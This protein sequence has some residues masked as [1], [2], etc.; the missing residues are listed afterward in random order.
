VI[1]LIDHLPAVGLSWSILCAHPGLF[2][3]IECFSKRGGCREIRIGLRFEWVPLGLKFPWHNETGGV[4]STRSS[5]LEPPQYLWYTH[6][7]FPAKPVGHEPEDRMV[8]LPE[9]LTR[10]RG[11][12]VVP[13]P[14]ANDPIESQ[15]L[16]TP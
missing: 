5:L 9:V 4:C 3:G 14:P 1:P 15:Y 10:A 11:R 8:Q 13:I 2:E 6:L 12:L 16:G 7:V